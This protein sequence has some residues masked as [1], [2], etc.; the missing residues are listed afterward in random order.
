[1]NTAPI[2]DMSGTVGSTLAD[3]L[4]ER[5]DQLQ[6]LA[7]RLRDAGPSDTLPPHR[8]LQLAAEVLGSLGDLE[9]QLHRLGA[10]LPPEPA[11]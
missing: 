8:L 7:H 6:A 10:W 5:G 4:T 9:V 2:L 1:M 11:A 3:L